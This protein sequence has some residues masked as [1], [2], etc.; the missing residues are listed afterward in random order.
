[1]TLITNELT[2][3]GVETV[4]SEK[5]TGLSYTHWKWFIRRE[6]GLV[7]F[8]EIQMCNHDYAQTNGLFETFGIS[9]AL[10]ASEKTT[11]FAHG[12]HFLTANIWVDC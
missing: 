9:I 3:T 10:G 11:R 8:K 7:L 4:L 2:F 12:R 6:T 5:F 1:M